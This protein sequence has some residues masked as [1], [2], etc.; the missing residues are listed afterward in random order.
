MQFKYIQPGFHIIPQ[1]GHAHVAKCVKSGQFLQLCMED[2]L[3][4]I[5]FQLLVSLSY[6]SKLP[7]T[8]PT[9]IAINS[10]HL[11]Y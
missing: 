7:K 2:I 11:M 5:N 3:A 10:I 4:Y 8:P 1:K 6:Q 9:H